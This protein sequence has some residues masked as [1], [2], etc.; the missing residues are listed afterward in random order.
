MSV[1][2]KLKLVSSRKIRTTNPVVHR[3]NKL[4]SKITEQIELAQANKEGRIYAP[5]RLKTVTNGDT[6]ERTVVES[7]KRVKE[8]FWNNDAGRIN[9]SIR[10]GSRVIELAKGKNAVEVANTDE[11]LQT[12]GVVREAVSAGELDEAITLAA[13]KLRSGFHK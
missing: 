4:L 13:D 7:A 11:L 6:G 8:W 9:L 1:L 5:K 2:A 3:R 12:L 10:Y